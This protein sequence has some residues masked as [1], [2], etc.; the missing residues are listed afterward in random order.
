M[1]E[2]KQVGKFLKKTGWA[3]KSI[4]A[5]IV[6]IKPS[7]LDDKALDAELSIQGQPETLIMSLSR[8]DENSLIS[9][10]GNDETKWLGK[11]VKI[12]FTE[13]R[14]I[15]INGQDRIIVTTKITS[16]FRKP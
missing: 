9:L 4:N 15:V 12:D 1:R 10:F 13:P 7:S 14:T 16:E 3:G 6:D 2:F 8:T 11:K 5:E